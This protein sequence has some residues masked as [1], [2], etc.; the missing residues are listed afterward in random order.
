[1]SFT[2]QHSNWIQPSKTKHAFGPPKFCI[3]INEA[4]MQEDPPM[5][6][7][8]CRIVIL[9]D[10]IS[11]GFWIQIGVLFI[12]SLQ[13][14]SSWLPQFPSQQK[15]SG[16][17]SGSPFSSPK[18]IHLEW[19]VPNPPKRCC[20][21]KNQPPRRLLSPSGPNS[22]TPADSRNSGHVNRVIPRVPTN[23]PII[24]LASTS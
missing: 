7:K 1:M 22:E 14:P 8:W 24:A 13:A 19:G 3:L 5:T 6:H 11:R 16:S 10:P 23:I 21:R 9:V 4:N 17:S 2:H 15:Q 12:K 18:S 20:R